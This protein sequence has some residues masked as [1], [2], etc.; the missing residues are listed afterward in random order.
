VGNQS[1]QKLMGENG[2]GMGAF[3]GRIGA[4]RGGNNVVDSWGAGQFTSLE[5]FALPRTV[6]FSLKFVF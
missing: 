1:I 5:T 3:E 2:M 4:G 6:Q